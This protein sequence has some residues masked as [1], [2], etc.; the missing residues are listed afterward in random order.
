M[1]PED[2]LV[3]CRNELVSMN[4]IRLLSGVSY[5]YIDPVYGSPTTLCCLTRNTA[6]INS[7][8]YI[9][10]LQYKTTWTIQGMNRMIRTITRR[11]MA[12]PGETPQKTTSFP[13]SIE[14]DYSFFEQCTPG[15]PMV[16]AAQMHV[17]LSSLTYRFQG[18]I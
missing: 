10:G 18:R 8:F 11:H 7:Q 14:T 16:L 1:T 9:K 12:Y 3:H 2:E 5:D 17:R 13:F 6:N 4:A 15:I